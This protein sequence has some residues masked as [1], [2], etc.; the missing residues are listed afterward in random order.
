VCHDVN[1]E[2]TEPLYVEL[3]HATIAES[4]LQELES[5]GDARKQ[6]M[7]RACRKNGPIAYPLKV[8]TTGIASPSLLDRAQN[9]PDV[10]GNLRLLKKQRTKERGNAVYIQP[11][12]KAS[13]RVADDTRFPLMEKVQ[14]FLSS[15]QKV[16]LLLGDSGAGKSTFSRE[17]EFELWQSYKSKT[18]RIPLHINLPTIEKPEHDMIAKQLR[19]TEFTEPQIREMKNHRK[20]ILICDGYDES[21]QTHNLYMSNELNQPGGWDAQMVIS[22]RSEYLGSD[23]QDRF[24]PG[25]RNKKSDSSLFQ[26]AL[27]TPFTLDQVHSYIKQ[28][29]SLRQP[30]WR[31]SDYMEALEHIPSLKE[32]VKN[33]F[34]MT[35]SLEVLP[36]IVD[37]GQHLSTARVTRVTLYDHF[38][39][40]WLERGKKRLGEKDLTPQARAT[41]ERLSSE[42]FTLNGIGY[43]KRLAVAI[44]KEQDGHPI[45]EYSQLN[46]EETWKVAF[47]N[48]KH[49]QLLLEA[50]PLTRNGNQHRFIH[51]SILE[52]G[53]A[54]AIFDPQDKKNRTTSRPVSGRRTRV[55][56]NSG[57]DS[58]D[59][60]DEESAIQEQE[61]DINSPLAWRSFVDEHS[62]LQ[63][64][65]ERVQQEPV[66]KDQLF[67][68]IEYSKKDKKWSK[69][70]ANAITILVR[71]G[72]Q[73]IGTDL[74]GIRIRGADLSCG[75]FDSV[76]LQGADLRKVNL[77][78]VWLRET[79]LSGSQMSGVQFGELPLLKSFGEVDAC[80]YSPDGTLF[81]VGLKY[82]GFIVVYSTLNWEHIMA[83]GGHSHDVRSIE[84]S[85]QEDQMASGCRDMT[86]RL[87]DVETGTCLHILTEH[88][89]EVNCVAYSPQG[90]Q[91]ASASDDKTIRFWDSATGECLRILIGHSDVVLCVAYAPNGKQIASG[92]EDLTVR[93]WS[94]DTG[95]CSGIFSGHSDLVW[96]IAYSPNGYQVASAGNDKT[97]R[98]WDVK[99]G[100]TGRIM[101]GHSSFVNSVAYSM[102]GT[103]VVSGGQDGTVR[104]WDVE[105]GTCHTW[106]GHSSS[107]TSVVYS[108][109]GD[110]IASGSYDGTIRLWDLS[111]RASGIVSSGHSSGVLDLKYSAKLDQ[112]VSGS[113]DNTIRLWD[114]ET[115]ICR[116]MLRGDG[117]EVTCVAFSPQGD[118][119]VSGSSGGT[120]Q[121]WE[122]ETG[123]C[124]HS[125]TGHTDFMC[126]VAYSP[127][128][129]LVASS[130]GDTT[131]KLWDVAN[132]NCRGNLEG[133]TESVRSVDFSPNGKWI[134]SGSHDGTVRIWDTGSLACRFILIGHDRCVWSVVFSPQGDR[135]ASGGD[136]GTIRLWNVETGDPQVTLDAH[137]KW[138]HCITYSPKGDLL[139]SGGYDKTVRIWDVASGE[140]RTVIPSFQGSLGGI[141]WTAS[142]KENCMYLV[143]GSGDGSVLKWQVSK[144][145]DVYRT[146]LE[147]GSTN[148]SLSTAGASI[149]DVRGLSRVN[150]ELMLQRGAVGEPENTLL[151]MGKRVLGMAS[152]L[153]KLKLKSHEIVPESPS[154]VNRPDEQSAQQEEQQD[155]QQDEQQ[156]GQRDE[157][158]D[159]QKDEQPTEAQTEQPTEEQVEHPIEGQ[160]EQPAEK[161]VEQK[162]EERIE[163]VVEHT[164]DS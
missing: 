27:I 80:A 52:Y 128:G 99:T 126:R 5:S 100:I 87:W 106:T 120:V 131:I 158:K 59:I 161:Q 103:R 74:R 16:F 96:A 38:V 91:I 54:R 105:T 114:V 76:Q 143:T 117:F 154:V 107:V 141:V 37:P 119:V 2:L 111:V 14:E 85:P 55:G 148:G 104:L 6:D 90:D 164:D 17:L 11:Q 8:S 113:G 89:D 129:D 21:Q 109:K 47:F 151:L 44:Y 25:D 19:R 125:F 71:A 118:Q 43:L 3:V 50:T 140:C 77:R 88:T 95:E 155:E 24:Q 29:V 152:V 132:R 39:E 78:G 92:S 121:L 67:A 138:V 69:A 98:I 1:E 70:A 136:S 123:T 40:Q 94:V 4:L 53:L 153:S 156:G 108:P 162:V 46:D 28:Y 97:I 144:D 63:F 42:G 137:T 149:Q 102:N 142:S 31:V 68:Y 64:L 41:F 61:P 86:V 146:R 35:L 81:A 51:R 139:A 32:L 82:N 163:Q 127:Q 130:G 84:F 147:W 34:L 45:V 62:L 101:T 116:R 18:G 79:D 73:F 75:M 65:E 9:R 12:A 134:A 26:E 57:H 49:K 157:Q 124:Q 56:S 15:E 135:L 159:E 33:P 7:Y 122:V 115:G 160:V 13:I 72:L 22:C 133:H 36:R 110:Q 10:E 48:P 60:S 23:Y 93:L 66:F 145:A 20:F 112:I 83:L 30:L 150:K 58:E